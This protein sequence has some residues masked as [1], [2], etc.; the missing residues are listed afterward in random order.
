M[1]SRKLQFPIVGEKIELC[2][3]IKAT[4]LV[5]SG[6]EAK[7]VVSE[8]MVS[9]NGEPERRKRKKVVAGDI[10]TF[11]DTVISVVRD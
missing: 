6:G 2:K 11:C 10:V 7:L 5:A 4:N 9:V 1:T 8:G 3:L